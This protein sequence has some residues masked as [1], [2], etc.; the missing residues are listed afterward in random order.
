MEEWKYLAMVIDRLLFY[1]FSSAFLF[2][3]FYIFMD[4]PRLFDFRI[5]I[6]K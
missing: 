2:G 4:H 5:P 3:T 6:Q 1:I